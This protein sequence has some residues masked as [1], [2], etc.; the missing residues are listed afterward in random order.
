MIYKVNNRKG[1]GKKFELVTFAFRAFVK[2]TSVNTQGIKSVVSSIG[3]ALSGWTAHKMPFVAEL[4]NPS[5]TQHCLD[6]G[7]ARTHPRS[8]TMFHCHTTECC[9]LP[10][11]VRVH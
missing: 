2:S 11:L 5:T 7:G 3:L 4:K 6:R 10:L 9:E 8:P 1:M